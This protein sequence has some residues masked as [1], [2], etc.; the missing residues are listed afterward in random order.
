MREKK[1]KFFSNSLIAIANIFA[2]V[3]NIKIRYK[4]MKN[5]TV[6]YQDLSIESS[7]FLLKP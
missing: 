1:E 4:I 6:V 7:F 3:N 5:R 2:F